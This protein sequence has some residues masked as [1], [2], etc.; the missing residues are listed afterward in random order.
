[1]DATVNLA[2][3]GDICTRASSE[4]SGFILVDRD[5]IAESLLT[6]S[7]RLF[8]GRTC[9]PEPEAIT[10]IIRMLQQVILPNYFTP[11]DPED[12][13]DT[14]GKLH[15]MLAMQIHRAIF[16][17]CYQED[18]LSPTRVVAEEKADQLIA[19][20][21]EL[22]EMLFE[23]VVE[24]YH[25]DPAATG[26]DEIILTYP[27]IFALSVYRVANVLFNLSVPL[28]PRM[29]TEYAH[30]LT[31]VDLH[32]GA[33]IGRGIMI[34]HGT[35]IVVGETT[36]VGNHVRIYQGVTL[37]ALYFPRDEAGAMVR[38]TKRHP[39]V[40]DDVI[41]YANATVL[42]GDTTIGHHSV[43]GSNAWVTE[44]VEPYSKVLYQ[45]ET[46]VRTKQG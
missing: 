44:S 42:G 9:Y 28:L 11:M 16:Q 40:E 31:G 22:Q 35:G 30:R 46:I 23:D 3:T 41:L 34:D 13:K 1:M 18:E 12:F 4:R 8:K 45:T 17:T 21:P 39:T 10:Q 2:E 24:T 7:C 6:T 20:L 43:I 36:I 5:E 29:M 27:G 25:S 32:P 38:T 37:G 19:K 15:G 33:T 14:I 26:Y